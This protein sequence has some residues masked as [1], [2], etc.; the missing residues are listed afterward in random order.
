MANY[1]Q[2]FTE[3]ELLTRL[4]DME[5]IRDLMAKRCYYIAS[6]KRREEISDL[7]VRKRDNTATAT[8]GRNWGYYVGMEEII[9]YYVLSHYDKRVADRE[10]YLKAFPEKKDDIELGF[11]SMATHTLSTPLIRLSLDG[12]T[13]RGLWYDFSQETTGKPDGTA[14]AMVITGQVAADFMREDGEWRIWHLFL[15]TDVSIPL[16]RPYSE[17]PIYRQPGTDSIENEFG[18][19]TIQMLAHNSVFGWGDLHPPMPEHYYSF[20]SAN[21]YAPE[22][23]PKYREM[24]G[25]L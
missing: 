23:H 11:G 24:E 4:W 7:W 20:D 1:N 25:L 17:T 6:D 8:F 5:D 12:K 13:A 2:N 22:G 21:S 19:P 16:G 10:P 14:E 9:K 15:S 18:T 3:T